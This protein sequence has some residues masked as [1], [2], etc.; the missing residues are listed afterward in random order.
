MA[1]LSPSVMLYGPNPVEKV[2]GKRYIQW[3]DG[4]LFASATLALRKLPQAAVFGKAKKK[5]T[6][7]ESE[8]YDGYEKLLAVVAEATAADLVAKINAE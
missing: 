5:T 8:G 6:A 3:K 1:A 4:Q 2:E 7:I